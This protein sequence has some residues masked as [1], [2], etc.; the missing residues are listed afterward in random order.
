V[1]YGLLL[2]IPLRP[3]GL[4]TLIVLSAVLTFSL[5]VGPFGIPLILILPEPQRPPSS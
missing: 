2:F 5:R 4:I 1:R 3:V